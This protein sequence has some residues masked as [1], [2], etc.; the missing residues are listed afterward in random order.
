[1]QDFAT[2]PGTSGAYPD[3]VAQDETVPGTSDDGTKL[4]AQ[5]VSEFFGFAQAVINGSFPGGPDGTID[6]DATGSQLLEAIRRHCGNAGEIVAW[7]GIG[8]IP[9]G[10][11]LLKLTGQDITVAS[12]PALVAAVY[13]G[14]PD[15][16]TAPAFYRHN[17]GVRNVA[18]VS[19]RLPD[20]RGYFLRG[21]GGIDPESITRVLPGSSQAESIHQHGHDK[22]YISGSATELK[23]NVNA[24]AGAAKRAFSIAGD[25]AST[26]TTGTGIGT[27]ATNETRPANIAV[28]WCVRF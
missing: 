12:Y 17:A 23:S 6:C 19:M 10:V 28:T 1:M 24:D 22:L 14:D 27:G 25:S 5:W 2:V 15:N 16:P 26:G 9:A 11:R 3:V 21:L 4:V 20:L 8:A 18:G 13:I 7:A